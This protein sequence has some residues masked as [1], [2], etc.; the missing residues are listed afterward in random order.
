MFQTKKGRRKRLMEAPLSP[1]RLTIIERNVPYY[2]EL[3]PGDRRELEGLMQVFLAEKAFEG[4]NGLEMTDEIRV[5]IAALACMLL[6]HRDTDF[7]PLLKSVLVYPETFIA[8]VTT[9]EPGGVVIE[10]EEERD[11]ESWDIGA[12]VLSW[13]EVLESVADPHDGYNVVFHEFAHQLDDEWGVADGAPPLP[14]RSMYDEWA[15][16]FKREYDA[17]VA[18]DDREEETFLDPYGAESPAE[19]FVVVTECFFETPVELREEHP[20]IYEQLRLFFEQNPA[21]WPGRA[22][23]E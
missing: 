5:T 1:E 4:C 7:Y 18:A 21:S 19:F 6:L 12:L 20:D 13:N 16:V 8:P 3:S 2:A 10:D 17:L 23:P 15:R 9:R 14:K 11:G 22:G